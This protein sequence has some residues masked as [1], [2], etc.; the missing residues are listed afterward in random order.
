MSI[1]STDDCLCV[2][3]SS[4]TLS[5]DEQLSLMFDEFTA[6]SAGRMGAEELKSLLVSVFYATAPDATLYDMIAPFD[7][8]QDGQLLSSEFVSLASSSLS[9]SSSSSSSSSESPCCHSGLMCGGALTSQTFAISRQIRDLGAIEPKRNGV[10]R[11]AFGSVNF[12]L[13][14]T[15][16]ENGLL[17]C[18]N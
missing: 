10:L 7:M 17:V 6:Q 4:N 3:S 1:F 8:D 13:G 11:V 12:G 2:L 18:T 15:P 9:S 5:T 16:S 14:L